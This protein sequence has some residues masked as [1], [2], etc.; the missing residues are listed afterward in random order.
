MDGWMIRVGRCLCVRVGTGVLCGAMGS[1]AINHEGFIQ[2]EGGGA[3]T[4]SQQ[5]ANEVSGLPGGLFSRVSA[6]HL[7][8]G[9]AAYQ[10]GRGCP[11]CGFALGRREGGG[12]GMGRGR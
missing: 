5:R 2:G 7:A 6:H 11:A 10:R 9:N 4:V 12:A 3:S 8:H 1:R